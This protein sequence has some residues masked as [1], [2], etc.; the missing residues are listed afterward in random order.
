MSEDDLE[1]T[2]TGKVA[3]VVV[4]AVIEQSMIDDGSCAKSRGLYIICDRSHAAL[5]ELYVLNFKAAL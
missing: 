3:C 2:A 1:L 4:F 5:S